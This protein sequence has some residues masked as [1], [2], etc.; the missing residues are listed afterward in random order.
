MPFTPNLNLTR[1]NLLNTTTIDIVMHTPPGSQGQ[2]IIMPQG[3]VHYFIVKVTTDGRTPQYEQAY[4]QTA[5]YMSDPGPSN[6][7]DAEPVPATEPSNSTPVE[8]DKARGRKRAKTQV[9]VV[10]WKFCFW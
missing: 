5:P 3:Y 8:A 10:F 7:P 1:F 4:E 2:M 6:T 9:N